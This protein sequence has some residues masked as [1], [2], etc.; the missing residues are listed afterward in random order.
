VYDHQ[1]NVWGKDPATGAGRRPLDNVG[2]QHG[3]AALNAG[4]IS[5]DQFLD[6]N[7][8]VG[9]FDTDANFRPGPGPWPTP[10]PS[11]RRTRRGS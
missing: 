10:T 3:L 1:A 6:L 9:G 8:K 7:D 5:V 11:I 4:E 2:I